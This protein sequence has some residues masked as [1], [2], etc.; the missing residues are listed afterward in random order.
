MPEWKEE[1]L[2]RLAPLKL[3]PTREADIVDELSQHLDDRYQEL[4][5]S[6]QSED[7]AFR[8]ALDELKGE[9][10]LARSLKPVEKAFYREPIVPGKAGTTFFDGILQDI[11]FAFRMF[12]KSPGFTAVAVLTLALGIG[13]N[14]AIFSLINA[15]MLRSLPI[16]NPQQLLIVEW[17]AAHDPNTSSSYSWSACPGISTDSSAPPGG[18]TFSY[19]TFEQLHS[20][21]DIFSDLCAFIA[22]QDEHLTLNGSVSMASGFLVSGDF[23]ATLGARAALGR[24]LG[25][26]DDQLG[27]QPTAM[28]SYAFWKGRFNGDPSII[29]KSILLEKTLFTVVGIT[30]PEFTGIDP[31]L[32]VD[33]WMPL[34]SQAYVAPYFPKRTAAN[35]TWLEMMARLKPGVS[36]SQAQSALSVVFANAAATGSTAMFKPTDSPKIELISAER[37][38]TSLR[39]EFSQPL[40]VLMACVGIILLIACANVGGL[41]LARASS[42]RQ[43]IAIRLTLGATRGRVARQLLTE[44][45]L[46]S[47][48]G[49]AL[50]IL[51]AYWSASALTAFLSAN[52]YSPIDLDVR[53]DG[54]V[55]AFTIAVAVLAAVLFG[56]APALQGTRMDLA[57]AIKGAGNKPVAFFGA[58]RFPFSSLLVVAQAALS[59]VVL[60]GAGLLVRTLINLERMNVGFETDHLLLFSV[61]MTIAGHT[62]FDKSPQVYQLDRALQTRLAALP[63]VTSATYSMVPLLSGGSMTDDF[64]LPA[65]PPSSAFSADELPVG[66]DFFETVRIPLVSGR[67]F[68]PADFESSGKLQPAL[69]N[70]SFAKKLFGTANPLGRGVGG[71]DSKEAQWQIIGV[72]GDAKYNS[73]REAIAP[74][75]YTLQK[76]SGAEFELRTRSNPTALIASVR[77]AVTHVNSRLLLSDFKSQTEQIDQLLYQERLVAGLSSLFGALSLLLACIGL[78]GM[79]SYEIVR[80][81]R[82]LG[83]RVALGAQR[84]DLLRFVVSQGIFLMLIGAAVGIS[85][86]IGVTRFVASLLYGV[87]AADPLTF[88]VVSLLLLAVALLA[89]YIPARRATRID[90]MVALRYE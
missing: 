27:S 16:H 30:A 29:G 23:F 83:I 71:G 44:S 10:L 35:S 66:P 20:R 24:T 5:A 33:V 78:Y 73:L 31:G 39:R 41:F 53:P 36:R 3:A 85:A 7:A 88:A 60:A 82:E 14:T 58:H 77:D 1:I 47:L 59:I 57:T 15:V 40:F 26:A 8:S 64:K 32:P 55:L 46:T 87:H 43:E 63:G 69:I 48:L 2:R 62:V 11:R 76:R 56:L 52:S 17:R 42:R 45:L 12:R 68:T 38:L 34:S 81:T 86:A 13:A 25:P 70:Q 79:L 49:A 19:P 50:G 90:P 18:C 72:V 61:D 51:L 84:R 74:T 28:L 37:G 22:S 9:E 89:C 4:L 65:A 21:S 80:R 54:L 75:I 6:G 67:T